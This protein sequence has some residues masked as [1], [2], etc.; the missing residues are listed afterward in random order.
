MW[1]RISCLAA[2][3]LLTLGSA[4]GA[5]PSRVRV[6]T[7]P[8]A[9]ITELRS[10]HLLP[11][12]LRADRMLRGGTYDPMTMRSHANRALWQAVGREFV[13]RGYVDSEWMPDFVVA[14]YASVDERLELSSWLYGYTNSPPWWSLGSIDESPTLFPAGTVVVDVVDPESLDVLWRGAGTTTISADPLENAREV[15]AMATTIV[16]RFPR[17][18][19]VVIAKGR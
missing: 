10:F 19:P 1:F 16:D 13:D 12:P 15:I 7:A 4:G 9:K 3:G 8:R 11:T 14:I 5:Q 18:R 6:M 2:A 17:A